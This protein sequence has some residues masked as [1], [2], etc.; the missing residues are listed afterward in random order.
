MF[1]VCF[2]RLFTPLSLVSVSYGVEWVPVEMKAEHL[3][4]CHFDNSQS[5]TDNTISKQLQTSNLTMN[6]SQ[7]GGSLLNSL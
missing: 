3:Y 2:I 4:F 5:N 1:P 7:V 6:I